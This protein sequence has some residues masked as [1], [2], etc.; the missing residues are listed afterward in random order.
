[1]LLMISRVQNPAFLQKKP[2][3]CYSQGTLPS[4]TVS[5]VF[6]YENTRLFRLPFHLTLEG[7]AAP[8]V[9]G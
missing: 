4:A 6:V 5:Y 7:D 8:V 9:R 3:F 2:P 1:M